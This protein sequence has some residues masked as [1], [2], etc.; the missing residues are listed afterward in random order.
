MSA[1]EIQETTET[2]ERAFLVRA[3][4]ADI[5]AGT[6]RT[7]DVRIVPYGET[8]T[9]NDGFGG[10]A[11]GVPYQ[12]Q[13]MPGVF[14]HQ[15][16]AANRVLAN[17]EHQLGIQGIVGHGLALREASDGFHGSFKAHE[18]A[19]GDKALMLVNE[20][21]FSGISLEAQPVKN[22]RTSAGVVQRVKANLRGIAF[23]RQGA[24]AGAQVL[25]VREAHNVV[26]EID[27]SLLP[28]DMDPETVERCRRLGISLPQRYQ[29][30]PADT[31]AQTGTSE[32]A[33]VESSDN[34]TSSEEGNGRDEAE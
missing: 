18:N 17:V 28:V 14:N 11:R 7:I 23:C 30:H 13:W 32:A 12:E 31:P 9:V 20:G 25:A 29:T 21:V 4:D 6:G 1:A 15:L 8:A 33:P 2:P 5:A 26:D 24:F 27:E 3:Y 16:N 10:V 19:D 34:S 22:I